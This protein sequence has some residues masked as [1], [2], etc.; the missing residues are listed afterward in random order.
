M[1]TAIVAAL[2]FRVILIKVS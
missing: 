1:Y 2:I